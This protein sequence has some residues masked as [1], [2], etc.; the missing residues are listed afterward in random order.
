MTTGEAIEKMLQEK[1]I[2]SKINYE[3]LKSLNVGSTENKPALPP[4]PEDISFVSPKAV[5]IR[6]PAIVNPRLYKF[7]FFHTLIYFYFILN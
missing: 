4:I 1:R 5:S 2:S 6:E 7:H 3:V